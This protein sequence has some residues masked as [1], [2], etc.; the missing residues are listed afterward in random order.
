MRTRGELAARVWNVIRL[1]SPV[2]PALPSLPITAPFNPVGLGRSM[3]SG[4]VRR[5]NLNSE[6]EM[7][8]SS[9]TVSLSVFGEGGD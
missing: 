6:S 1:C 8:R 4:K 9:A 7:R 5:D 2:L 3:S